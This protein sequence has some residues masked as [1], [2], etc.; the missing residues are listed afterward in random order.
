[1][2]CDLA[3]TDPKAAKDMQRGITNR[4]PSREKTAP[5]PNSPVS[6]PA[7]TKKEKILGP[8][9]D[10]LFTPVFFPPPRSGFVVVY[11]VRACCGLLG[12]GFLWFMGSGLVVVYWVRA[13]CDLFGQGLLW[14]IRSGL[15]ADQGFL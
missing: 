2:C 14:L 5:P 8:Y 10:T 13:C 11:W 6:E 9:D 1:M 12:Q 4:S 7:E 15:V 3:Q